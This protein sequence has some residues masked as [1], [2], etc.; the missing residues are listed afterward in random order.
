[1]KKINIKEILHRR[2]YESIRPNFVEGVEG[3]KSAEISANWFLIMDTSTTA[4]LIEGI[5]EIVEAVIDK[6][7]K[8]VKMYKEETLV[9]KNGKFVSPY[10]EVTE[11]DLDTYNGNE[12]YDEAPIVVKVDE[13]SI[14]KIK[15]MIDYEK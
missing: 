14:L 12:G 11:R 13:E 8:E 5:K 1:M 3:D 7:A 4:G 2:I 6:C 15:Q 10:Q 9:Y